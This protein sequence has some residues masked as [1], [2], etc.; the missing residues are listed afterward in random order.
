M[1]K[2]NFNYKKII[3]VI[4]LAVFVWVAMGHVA[5]AQVAGI[6][7]S[8]FGL[9]GTSLDIFNIVLSYF[10]NVILEI[11]S[12]LVSLTGILLNVSM[13]LTTH[14]GS[15]INDTPVIYTVW[16]II[17]DFASVILIFFILFAAIQ[18]IL[19]LK[20]A[21][22]QSLI[23]SIIVMGILIN[24]SF[25]F[26][27]VIIDASN[28]VS[29]QFYN[30]MAPTA[31]D[32][33]SGKIKIS[34]LA[35]RMISSGGI[36]DVFMGSLQ[37]QSWSG[38]Y[39]MLKDTNYSHSLQIVLM[40]VGGI[41]VMIVTSLS[42]IAAAAAGIVRLAMLIFLLVFSPIWVATWALP[43]IKKYT[44]KWS[45]AFW[46]QILF[47]PVYL[48]FMYVAIRVLTESGLTNFIGSTTSA[49]TLQGGL[50]PFI[51]IFVGFSIVIFMLNIPLYIAVQIAGSSMGWTEKM[52]KNM[53][54]SVKGWVGRNTLGTAAYGLNRSGAMAKLATFSPAAGRLAS[55]GLSGISSAGFSGK[56]GGYEGVLK[57]KKKEFEALH[58]RLG[59]V[60]RSDYATEEEFNEAKKR[61]G[62][63]Q[64]S[65]RENLPKRSI[66]YG[67]MTSRASRE[68]ATKLNKEALGDQIE[69]NEK[70]RDEIKLQM[71]TMA[72][73]ELALAFLTSSE[74]QEYNKLKKQYDEFNKKIA[75]GKKVRGDKDWKKF[76]EAVSKEG[77]ELGGSEEKPKPPA[78]GKTPPKTP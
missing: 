58:E 18:M 40:S 28:I 11:T 15:F 46:A 53:K 66:F 67:M 65:F 29:L 41:I 22:F 51:N 70:L 75:E 20:T 38:N 50:A 54:G 16:G 42:F 76:V 36:A 47:M 63:A 57:Q 44:E 45:N 59:E 43:Q 74:Q 13:Y 5:Q 77:K 21:N 4:C 78:S 3:P 72:K 27:R 12:W 61:A 55:K 17:R 56:K 68:S 30:A 6:I 37:I 1:D 8:L 39:G 10:A 71:D 48:M 34:D 25:F 2:F 32:F 24:F 9:S 62:A 23:F 26:T 73:N 14:I 60:E 33:G 52:F 49:S 35:P 64:Q 7:T 31:P 19:G 69:A